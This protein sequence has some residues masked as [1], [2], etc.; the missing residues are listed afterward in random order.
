MVMSAKELL[1]AVEAAETV[2]NDLMEAK[3]RGIN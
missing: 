1:I 3:R 2:G